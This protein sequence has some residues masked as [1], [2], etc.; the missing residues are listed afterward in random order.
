[1]KT[2]EL[3]ALYFDE[4][5]HDGLRLAHPGTS[6]MYTYMLNDW[7]IIADSQDCAALEII[8]IKRFSDHPEMYNTLDVA[9]CR[10]DH[11]IKRIKGGY[12]MRPADNSLALALHHTL[13]QYAKDIMLEAGYFKHRQTARYAIDEQ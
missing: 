4:P 9:C 6:Q 8:D 7:S 1:M 10:I 11:I 13:S 3:L 5:H 12:P 2:K